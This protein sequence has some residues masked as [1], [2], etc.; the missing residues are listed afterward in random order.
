MLAGADVVHAGV[1]EPD[2]PA[3]DQIKTAC[4]STARVVFEVPESLARDIAGGYVPGS[5]AGWPLRF[6]GPGGIAIDSG[7]APAEVAGLVATVDALRADEGLR[8]DG[9]LRKGD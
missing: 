6:T 2:C 4:R 1:G 3:L 7:L 8:S 9:G 5:R